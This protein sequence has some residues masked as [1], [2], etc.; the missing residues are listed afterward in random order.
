MAKKISADARRELVQAIGERYRAGS[1]QEKTRILDEFV[2]VTGF[3]RK[4]SIRVLKQVA[5]ASAP[6][7]RSR[8]RVYDAAVREALAFSGK[9]PTVSAARG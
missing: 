9:P 5:S 4:H 8:L 3:R 1:K 6:V 7:R 2:A